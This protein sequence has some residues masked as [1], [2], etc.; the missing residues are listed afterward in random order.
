[1]K[2][3]GYGLMTPIEIKRIS[4]PD[5]AQGWRKSYATQWMW[6]WKDEIGTWIEYGKQVSSLFPT[7]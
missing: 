5:V 2:V 7:F 1:M 6:Y 3:E 4:P